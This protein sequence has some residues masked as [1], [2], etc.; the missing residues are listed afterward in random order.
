MTSPIRARRWKA[1]FLGAIV[2]MFGTV[3]IAQ[4]IGTTTAVTIL[5]TGQPPGSSARELEIGT[6]VVANERL[7][8]SQSGRAQL[9]FQDRS[10][11][12][13]APN[14]DLVLDEYVYD[15]ETKTGKVVFSATKGFFRFV[16][17]LIS[18]QNAVEFRTPL[19]TIGLRGGIADIDISAES[20]VAIKHFGVDLTVAPGPP[21]DTAQQFR[22]VRNGFKATV[23]E[24]GGRV[25]IEKVSQTEIDGN[26]AK[27]EGAPADGSDGP[28]QPVADAG[29]SR[30]PAELAPI[31]HPAIQETIAGNSELESDIVEDNRDLADNLQEPDPPDNPDGPAPVAYSG[32]YQ[33]NPVQDFDN[34][35]IGSYVL[36]LIPAHNAT[37]GGG[38]I[39][40]DWFTAAVNGQRVRL[41]AP[42]PSA[43]TFDSAGT[44][45]PFGPVSGT[46]FYSPKQDFF[47]YILQ[48]IDNANNLATIFGGVPLAT[49]LFPT[50]GFATHSYQFGHPIPAAAGGSVIELID[51]LTL[52]SAYGDYNRFISVVGGGAV[53][54]D[55]SG[56]GQR[57]AMIGTTGQYERQRLVVEGG[58]RDGPLEVAAT[59][60]SSAR[61]SSTDHPVHTY[62]S[63]TSVSD[64]NG[65]DFF[66]V[67]APD[68]FVTG[69]HSYARHG[70]IRDIDRLALY[71]SLGGTADLGR[72]FHTNGFAQPAVAPA[73]LGSTRTTR[74]LFG[75]TGGIIEVRS[76]GA[77][78][79]DHVFNSDPNNRGRTAIPA[80]SPSDQTGLWIFTDADRRAV[81]VEL[82]TEN[83]APN[84]SN[85]FYYFGN[86]YSPGSRSAFV[87]DFRFGARNPRSDSRSF[88]GY[89]TL[90][91]DSI[92]R[93]NGMFATTE[94]FGSALP[95]SVTPCV[96]KYLRWGYWSADART[97]ADATDPNRRE[98]AHIA[99]WVAG[100]IP[101][102]IDIPMSGTAAYAGHIVGN[103]KN[104]ADYYVSAGRF[105]HQYDFG[106]DTG[107]F[108]V[109]D[110]D[111]ADYAGPTSAS[112][113]RNDFRGTNIQGSLDRNMNLRGS[114][115]KTRSQG[116]GA[117]PAY[118]GGDFN[119]ADGGDYKAGGTFA[120]DR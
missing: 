110:F 107:I 68:Y 90:G 63:T 38:R 117:I 7:V 4:E 66:G 58:P 5:T 103:V 2:S 78:A 25:Q 77:F 89:G 60:I 6:D 84:S 53:V 22:I 93:L 50:S 95:D 21:G 40:D 34:A 9:I 20:V 46:G 105:T 76:G 55:G 99:S 112:N 19:A 42:S 94:M 30:E 12:T 82:G 111:S 43:F 28:E 11:L 17:G 15:P 74:T 115:Y 8:T 23:T 116:P 62:F 49:E 72:A 14:S 36:P 91:N 71:Q 83:V 98:A 108:S 88:N 114:F 113:L 56:P 120:G 65:N 64:E 59:A 33:R 97:G 86:R 96:C 37:Y 41:P 87:D 69:S 61:R 24:E 52:F 44:S 109:T 13:V 47:F 10:S 26:L 70:N 45:S 118:V 79:G 35:V 81:G 73:D 32:Q 106:T 54:F 29:S 102:A 51:E 101:D 48:E 119:V 1:A 31:D 27:L 16:G 39:E 80:V 100:E 18:K 75:Y 3:A 57:S 67:D 85:N 104:G 92:E